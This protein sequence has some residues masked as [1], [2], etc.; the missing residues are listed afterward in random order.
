[1]AF[2]LSSLIKR[3]DARRREKGERFVRVSYNDVEL[4]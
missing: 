3:R 4:I 1:M 2:D